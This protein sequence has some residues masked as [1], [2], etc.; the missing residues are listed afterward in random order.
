MFEKRLLKK[1][2]KSFCCFSENY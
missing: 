2:E 1:T